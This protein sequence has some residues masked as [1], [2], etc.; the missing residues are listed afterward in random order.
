MYCSSC[1]SEVQEGLKYCNR[2]GAN[3]GA[4]TAPPKLFAIVMVLALAVLLVGIAGVVAIFFFAVELMGRG[5]IPV[6]TIIFVIVFTLVVF[7]IEALLI[8][9][10]S[11]VFAVYTRQGGAP[12]AKKSE[13]KS[14]NKLT[15]ARQDFIAPESVHTT[16]S[17]EKTRRLDSEE[18]TRKLD[19]SQE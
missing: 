7:G 4:E 8:R 15:E 18:A 13:T 11:R 2:C 19:E 1:G 17:E 16:A 5:N 10:F 6:E 12:A 14:A 9:Q 3:L